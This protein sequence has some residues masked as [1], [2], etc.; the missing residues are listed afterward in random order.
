MSL[1]LPTL[2]ALAAY[3]PEDR[4][5]AM[6]RGDALPEQAHGAALFADAS[7]FTP[8][9][10]ALAQQFGPQRGAEELTGYLNR[11]YTALI[12]QVHRYGGSVVSYSGD[13]ITCWF[14]HDDGRRALA[15]GLGM[16]AALA[17]FAR[18]PLPSG[19]SFSLAVKVAVAVGDGRRL[20][21]GD[22][23]IRLIDVLGGAVADSLAA[24]SA[25]V[26]PGQVL[27]DSLAAQRLG[28]AGASV[29]APAAAPAYFSVTALPWPV[30]PA[31]WPALPPDA[32][33]QDQLRPWLFA[34]IY[35]RIV[36]GHGQ[37]LTELRTGVS[38]FLRFGGI[39]YED[40]AAGQRL[41]TYIRWVQSVLAHY[42]GQLLDVTL[43]EKGGY[44]YA[45]FGALV[46]HE[47]DS[48][49]AAAAALEL[50]APPSHLAFIAPVPIGMSRGTMRTGP[51]G[52]DQRRAYGVMG[53]EAN[54]AARLM[55]AAAAGQIIATRGVVKQ[56]AGLFET[57]ALPPLTVKG[58]AEPIPVFAL[59]GPASQA[60]RP[61][62]SHAGRTIGR[63]AERAQLDAAL[64]SLLAGQGGLV[65][66]EGEAGI[67]KS[68]LLADWLEAA[69]ALPVRVLLGESD[70][71]EQSTPYHAWRS[72]F[73]QL[74]F[75]PAAP[76]HPPGQ[77]G[78]DVRRAYVLDQLE[79]LGLAERAPLLNPVLPL[80]LP[81]NDLTARMTGKVR[82]D[83]THDVLVALLQ[84]AA[85]QQPLLLVLEDAH[86]L[87]STSWALAL[88]AFRQVQ[89][90]LLLLATRPLPEPAPPEYQHL[91]SRP[92]A[93]RL[94]LEALPHEDAVALVCQR[95]GVAGLP[96]ALASLLRHKAEGHPFFSE[97]LAYALRDAGLIAVEGGQVRVAPGVDLG[98]VLLPDTVEDVVTSRVD[99]LTPGQ[100]LT[101][102]VASV[103]GRSFPVRLLEEV[104]PV[105]ADR[106][107]LS[108]YLDLLQQLDFTSVSTPPPELGYI[109][110]HVI[111]REVVYSLLLFAQR[112]QLH[113]AVAEWYERAYARD[114]APVYPLLAHHWLSAS[115][116]A[117]GD[118]ESEAAT[119]KAIEYL[120][121]AGQAALRSD[122]S[123]EAAA[124]FEKLLAMAPADGA[125]ALGVGALRLAQWHHQL[126]EAY[127]RL[128][129]LDDSE[130]HFTR[131][132][133]YLG[134]PMPAAAGQL[135][136]GMLRQVGRQTATRLRPAGRANRPA[137]S[138][139]ALEA[140]RLACK[141]YERLGLLYFLKN[142]AGLTLYCPLA[143]LNLAEEIGPSPELAIAYSYVTGAAGLVPAH[144][145]ARR[146]EALALDTSQQV[147]N[148][149]ITAR[150]R[151]ATSVYTAGAGRL[152]HTAARLVQAIDAFEQ[153][154][155]WEWWGVS[156]EMLNRVLYYQGK[157]EQ[158]RASAERLYAMAR[159]REDAV[160]ETW[161]LTS[162]M[163]V[164]V[165]V[166][167]GDAV[168]ARTPEL[169]RLVLQ[170]GETGPRQKI[171]CL[172]ALA[173]LGRQEW[174]AA[175][176]SATALMAL[177]AGER[178]T[179]FG[180]LTVY[181]AAAETYLALWERDALPDA[182]HL[183]RQSAAAVKLLARFAGI[184]PIGQP[185]LFR[186][187]GTHAWLKGRPA[188][189]RAHWAKALARAQALDMPLEAA[190]AEFEL[191]RHLPPA[192]PARHAR[193]QR[194]QSA[195]R[196]MGVTYYDQLVAASLSEPAP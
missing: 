166:A 8:L 16:Q 41:D 192:D 28:L 7:G 114:L 195:L 141:I 11:F 117:A 147:D 169:E 140:R 60:P 196:Q 194:A 120:E 67:G 5:H 164:L 144:G 116:E 90:M 89:P 159:R 4:R 1:D 103:I 64:Q 115:H 49:R 106:P 178:P 186:L 18:S 42:E 121:K 24:G 77:P 56:L 145:L 173:H 134:L 133:A 55:S 180:L 86:W 12:Q 163:E 39:D 107:R 150:V 52:S 176:A 20:L 95:L 179:S 143:S 135:V 160:Q 177:I 32:L 44:L 80:E 47:D 138:A 170:T 76:S 2:A 132:L 30:A 102:K 110:K 72:V 146:Y 99:R 172:S 151:M 161:G 23:A 81:D 131:S 70:A 127:N 6:A 79:A 108:R 190:L 111:T 36:R 129:R 168:L 125:P 38:V 139:A 112:R 68:R 157:F 182:A 136:S 26:R 113:R 59:T 53:D 10:E 43:G 184:L 101:V 40:T 25:L 83:N 34:S 109:F 66:V 130:Q 185:A 82:S 45:A 93:L 156:V 162:L 118:A 71:I 158:A 88:A 35:D 33:N 123:R 155:T 137:L 175:E 29:A 63:L 171:H 165:L 187:Q 122:A 3:V 191:G 105:A 51:F 104:H 27:I 21:V 9:T 61:R 57:A 128:G 58:K 13:A 92:G 14:D 153:T 65:V 94:R 174:A 84:Q 181:T 74:L 149:V 19:D 22:P 148:P 183:Q 62:R 37:F 119:L 152:E 124:H 48:R 85:A 15:A 126:A 96:E 91:L 154:G 167:P 54:V 142:N 50:R 189:A 87:D 17:Q 73:S 188:A 69:A 193:L 31:P 46:L 75:P 97:E 98:Q 100:Q 78:P